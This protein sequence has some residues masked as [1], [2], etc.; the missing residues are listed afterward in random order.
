MVPVYSEASETLNLFSEPQC[1]N[2]QCTAEFC[3]MCKL[4]VCL[5]FINTFRAKS[6][7]IHVCQYG[8]ILSMVPKSRCPG[9][10]KRQDFFISLGD[11]KVL[12]R[13][14]CFP[15]EEQEGRKLSSD[16]VTQC[17]HSRRNFFC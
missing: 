11:S 1:F 13:L 4:K 12:M 16:A 14:F 15:R 8:E 5:G 9:S 2:T 7:L 6:C 17:D 3:S 10:Q